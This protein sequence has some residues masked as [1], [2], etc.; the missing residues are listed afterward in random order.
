MTSVPSRR[1]ALFAA[2]G[3]A[4]FLIACGGVNEP[5]PADIPRL[6]AAV[7]AEPG[8]LDL[9]TQLGIA[10][11]KDARYDVALS[12]LARAV[13]SGAETGAAYLYLG[14][15][16]EALE[17]WSGA[18]EAYSS[19]MNVG[20]WD[21]LKDDLEKR[22]LIIV[23]N[24]LQ[25]QA[26]TALAQESELSTQPPAPRS[27]AVFPF[28]LISDNEDLIPLQV[29]MAD[30]VITDLSISNALT[31]LERT[32]I[33]TLLD[34]MALTE[35]GYTDAGSGA[36]VG[37][38]LRAEHVVQGAMTTLAQEALRFDTNI[39]NTSSGNNAGDATAEDQLEA[40]FD[41]EK[42][43]VFDILADLGVQITPAEREAIDQN[44]SASLLAFLAYGQALMARDQGDYEAAEQF[45]EQA[46][47]LDPGFGMAE[48]A[49]AETID[50]IDASDVTPQDIEVAGGGELGDVGGGGLTGVGD[51]TVAGGN[52]MDLLDRTSNDVNPTRTVNV[53]DQ[54]ETSERG[55][56]RQGTERDPTQEATQQE[57]PTLTTGTIRVTIRRPSGGEQ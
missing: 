13:D 40:I 6:E 25:E 27:I 51:A 36:R 52:S 21:P 31:V 41:V 16:H 8:D 42:E 12:T 56:T 37:R 35:A 17:N 4:L 34:E 22:L 48:D 28:R 32:Q 26:R 45:F 24:E 46:R 23:R 33:Q 55:E 54:G 30:M 7:S 39:L 53:L 44:R 38:M 43:I 57:T 15:T 9:Q 5:T 10:Y 47:E 20:R 3:A 2:S 18:R 1:L 19:Y 50:L 14:L 49:L 29:A 11:Y